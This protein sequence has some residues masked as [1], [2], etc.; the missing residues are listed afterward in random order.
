[1]N[2]SIADIRKTY[3]MGSFNE[4]DANPSPFKQFDTWWQEAIQ[5]SIDEVNAMTLAT[6]DALHKPHARIVLLKGVDNTGFYFYTNYNSHKGQQ[7]EANNNAA[8]VIFWKEL[9]RQIRI[10]GV[11]QKADEAKSDAYFISRPF[12]SKIG[13]IA[14]PQSEVLINRQWLEQK[15]AELKQHLTETTALRPKH[16]GGYVLIPSQFEFW[17]GRPSRLHDRILYTKDAENAWTINRLAP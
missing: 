15:E 3:A 14:S 6:V 12:E 10:E 2:S 4:S 13:A 5:S 1:M 16:W 8:I 17:Q 9:E 7:I 11:I